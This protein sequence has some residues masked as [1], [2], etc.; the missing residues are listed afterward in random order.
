MAASKYEYNG[1][2]P[3]SEEKN[4]EPADQGQPVA[5]DRL[6]VLP[7]RDMVLFPGVVH[8]VTVRRPA[9]VA[10]AQAAIRENGK[11]GLLLQRKPE[12][13][14]PV[15]A[16]LYDVGTVVNILRYITA[17]DNAHHLICQGETRFRVTDFVDTSPHLVVRF[18]IPEEPAGREDEIEARVRV[19]KQQA[20][21]AIEFLPQVPG[22]LAASLHAIDS[23]GMLCDVIAGFL[24]IPTVEKQRLLETFD[25]KQRLDIVIDLMAKRLEILELSHEIEQQ[26]RASIDERQ[27]EAV[28]REQLR[29]IQQQLGEDEGDAAEFETI[30][31]AITDA[32]MPEEV[33][34]HTRKEFARLKRMPSAAGEYSMLRNYIDWLTELPWSKLDNEDID[35]AKARQILDEDH[36]GLDEIKKRIIEYLAVR[37][38]NPDGH[39]PILCFVGPPGVGKTSL[40]QSIARAVGLKFVRSSLGGT[41]DEAEIRGHRRTYIGALPGKIIQGI[42]KARTRNPVFMLDEIDKLG[43]SLHGDPASALL[44]VL[45]PEQNTTFQDNYLGVPFDL[46]KVMFIATAN[47]LDTIVPPLLD[48]M[49]VIELRG[50]STE[51]KLQ[52][53]RRYLV[54][55]QLENNGLSADQVEVSNEALLAIINGYT[56]EAGVR[57]LEKQVGA[58]LRHVAVTFAEGVT[59]KKMMDTDDVHRILGAPKFENEVAL[60]TGLPGVATGLAWTPVGGDIL[61]IECA[62]VPGSGKLILTGQLGDVMRESAQAAM[63]LVKSRFADAPEESKLLST[64]DVHIHVP[65]GAIPKDGPSAGV[66]IF[67]SLASLVT[68]QTVRHDVAM[69]G[70]ISL[71]GLVLPVGGIKEKVIAAHRAGIERV[72]L[73]DRNRKDYEDIPESVRSSVE[74][75]WL[76]TVDDALNAALVR[77]PGHA[78]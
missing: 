56:R 14:E 46:G 67:V 22:E 76:K 32:R 62:R 42:H 70:E 23:P 29:T 10:A 77:H 7:V 1:R 39:S 40:G 54:A 30:D 38:L 55:R 68:G 17:P 13:D 64:N 52:I 20:T 8:P 48:R 63:S 74:F 65:A 11:L 73:P 34:K 50:Y 44:E 24:D 53:A 4:P 18:A 16:D 58:V 19:L 72:L 66:A 41:H 21:K 25:I 49:E 37:K 12:T 43:A 78:A 57:N 36:Y 59:A 6:H 75:I 45:D 35:I 15:A 33:E 26:T 47:R 31:K 2:Y 61:F 71:R 51:E 5:S 28:L 69:T 3:M 9:S 27:R 60:R